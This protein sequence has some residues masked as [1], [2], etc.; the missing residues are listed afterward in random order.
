MVIISTVFSLTECVRLNRYAK[1]FFVYGVFKDSEVA[2]G[3]STNIDL[4]CSGAD[5]EEHSWVS[6]ERYI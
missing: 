1:F 3:W 5:D 4:P 2:R 6:V